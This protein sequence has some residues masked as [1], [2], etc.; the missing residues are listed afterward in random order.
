MIK[1]Y[2]IC[3]VKNLRLNSDL[4]SSAKRMKLIMQYGVGLEG[5][6]SETF[7]NLSLGVLTLS[8]CV[9]SVDLM[10]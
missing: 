3:V 7:T 10:C 8:D 5:L 4:I 1:D 6:C 2:D 9:L